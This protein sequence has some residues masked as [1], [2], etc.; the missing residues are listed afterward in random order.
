M[1]SV[2]SDCVTDWPGIC[3]TEIQSMTSFNHSLSTFILSI[4]TCVAA[5]LQSEM[6]R[7]RIW[8]SKRPYYLPDPAKNLAVLALCYPSNLFLPLLTDSLTL[9]LLSLIILTIRQFYPARHDCFDWRKQ[10]IWMFFFFRKGAGERIT[11][12][13]I[14]YLNALETPITNVD[15]DKMKGN[16]IFQVRTYKK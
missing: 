1:Q 5:K 3:V 16:Y 2:I 12:W 9:L 7:I 4:E 13:T 6:A 15:P 10:S 8:A 11:D 14:L